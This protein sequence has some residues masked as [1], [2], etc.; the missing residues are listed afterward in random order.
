[1][2]FAKTALV[3]L[4]ATGMPL[5]TVII[6]GSMAAHAQEAQSTPKAK[7]QMAHHRGGD[8]R[9]NMMR[10]GRMM[11]MLNQFDTDGDRALTQEEVTAA[12]AAQLAEFDADGN[13]ELT[14]AEY[15]ALWLD[16]MRERMVDRFQSHDDDGTGTITLEEFQEDVARLVERG[17]RNGDGVLNS[18]DFMRR[19]GERERSQE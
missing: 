7:V 11:Q 8:R 2:T 6:G 13:G 3:V 9:A 12:R 5:G 19:G 14:L 1:M 16:A 18:D 4:L 15:E 17:D 10:S